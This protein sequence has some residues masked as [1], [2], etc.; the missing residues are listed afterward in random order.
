LRRNFLRLWSSEYFL[1]FVM[2]SPP[3]RMLR[4]MHL[5]RHIQVASFERDE[6]GA[7]TPHR[8]IENG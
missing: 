7:E 4:K 8:T 6:G 2:G 5:Y 1:A 3:V